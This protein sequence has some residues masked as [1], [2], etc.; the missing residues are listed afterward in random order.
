MMWF[1]G[2]AAMGALY[3][4]SPLA[5]VAFGIASEIGAMVVFLW[6]DRTRLLESANPRS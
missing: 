1:A 3:D 5:L 4:L 6:L 2:S